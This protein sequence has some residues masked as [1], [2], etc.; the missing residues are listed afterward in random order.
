MLRI[1]MS[2]THTG[3][4]LQA[5][6]A[7]RTSQVGYY[8][9]LLLDYPPMKE[10]LIHLIKRTDVLHNWDK[11]VDFS[12]PMADETNKKPSVKKKIIRKIKSF[13]IIK[14]VYSILLEK[15]LLQ[16]KK[17]H[18]T[19][20]KLELGSNLNKQVQLNVLTKTGLNET[21]FEFF[22]NAEVNYFEH[23]IGDYMYYM[24]DTIKEGNFYCLFN[25]EFSAY[26]KINN[27]KSANKVFGYLHENDFSLA[28][29]N[30]V[31]QEVVK[32]EG[33][34]EEGKLV[35][36][37]MENV[38]MYEVENFFW[39]DY[40]DFCL[41]KILTPED[42]TFIIKP[43]HMQSFEAIEMTTA[44]LSKRGL[45]HKVLA[46]NCFMHMGAEVVFYFFQEKTEYVFSLFSSSIYYFTKLYPSPHIKY[47]HGYKLFA[48]YTKNAPKQ[49]LEIYENLNPIITNVVSKNCLEI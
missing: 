12:T 30:L 9:V 34:S 5:I 32:A 33:A 20:L 16:Q 35:F 8:D 48:N 36:I 22:P 47:F 15:H 39:T 42:Y 7:N 37:L 3:A 49:F 43:H 11:V 2:S 23:G 13:P 38:E 46:N 40:I 24:M 27:S 4:I 41:R 45:K 19:K 28:I 29:D 10:S 26:L 14:S 21:L 1:F 31:K 17:T 25:Q 18:L 6:Y 44:Y